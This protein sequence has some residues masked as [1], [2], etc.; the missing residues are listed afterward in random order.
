[1]GS[2]HPRGP[3]CG[4][5]PS[6]TIGPPAVEPLIDALKDADW[7]VQRS[8]AAVLGKI[9]GDRAVERLLTSL[10]EHDLGVIVGAILSIFKGVSRDQRML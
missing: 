10:R 3:G 7:K 6:E 9:K 2:G 5:T 8:A 4:R 1:M